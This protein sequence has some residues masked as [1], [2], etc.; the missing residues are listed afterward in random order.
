MAKSTTNSCL[1]ETMKNEQPIIETNSPELQSA[2][3]AIV[4][5]ETDIAMHKAAVNRLTLRIIELDTAI[6]ECTVKANERAVMADMSVPDMKALAGRK[7]AAQSEIAVLE[8][9]KAL[10]VNELNGLNQHEHWLVD[11]RTEVVKDAWKSL[12]NQM[13]KT[14]PLDELR[15][16]ISIGYLCHIPQGKIAE[17]ILPDSYDAALLEVIAEKYGLPL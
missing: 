5:A 13:M 12:F 17:M 2:L 1:D 14:L 6:A 4:A 9:V 15:T 7:I 11:S 16:M 10:A 8:E 3:D